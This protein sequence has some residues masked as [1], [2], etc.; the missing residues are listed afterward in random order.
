MSY[1]YMDVE[2]DRDRAAVELVEAAAYAFTAV[3]DNTRR[4]HLFADHKPGQWLESLPADQRLLL[5]SL[6]SKSLNNRRE[7]HFRMFL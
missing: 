1:R 3:F 2:G 7:D 5:R 4:K 6:T